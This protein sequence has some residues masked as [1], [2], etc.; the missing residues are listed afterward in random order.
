MNTGTQNESTRAK[1]WRWLNKFNKETEKWL[2]NINWAL[3]PT[4]FIE[5]GNQIS[6]PGVDGFTRYYAGEV[7]LLPSTWTAEILAPAFKKYVA[8]TSVDGTPVKADDPV[9]AGLLGKVIPGSVN[10]I[11][12]TIEAGKSYTIQY[13]AVDYE[14]NIRTLNY[15]IKGN[16]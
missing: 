6:R 5:V 7:K 10:E 14:G 8:I 4:M 13:S 3:Q 15:R 9:N 12:F 16:N 1:I 2:N 11:P